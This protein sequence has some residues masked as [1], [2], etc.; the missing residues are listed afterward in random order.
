MSRDISFTFTARK[1]KNRIPYHSA[2]F[3]ADTRRQIIILRCSY[4]RLRY[5]PEL[6]PP[7]LHK[8]YASN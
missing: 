4:H 7:I 6:G 5:V 1:E 8:M 3:N 2:S